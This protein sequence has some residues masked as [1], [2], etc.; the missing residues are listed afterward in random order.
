MSK[1][2]WNQQSTSHAECEFHSVNTVVKCLDASKPQGNGKTSY[3]AGFGAN[4]SGVFVKLCTGI[5]LSSWWI[6]LVSEIKST[7]FGRSIEVS[8]WNMITSVVRLI[9]R[10]LLKSLFH[11]KKNECQFWSKISFWTSYFAMYSSNH[12]SLPQL[13]HSCTVSYMTWTIQVNEC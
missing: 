8:L 5:Y 4:P 13:G 6:L 10:L 9:V 11:G 12:K 7:V 2:V 1:W 3:K